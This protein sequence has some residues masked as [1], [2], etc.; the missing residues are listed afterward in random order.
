MLSD[1]VKVSYS[2]TRK[3]RKLN[4]KISHNLSE[5]PVPEA[6]PRIKGTTAIV[7][8]ARNIIWERSEGIIAGT[9]DALRTSM[10]LFGAKR[11]LP[12]PDGIDIHQLRHLLW[13]I[14]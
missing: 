6:Y 4:R 7:D 9:L 2:Y 14:D 11:K 3:R 8:E 1:G 12:E 13:S 5:R 10:Y